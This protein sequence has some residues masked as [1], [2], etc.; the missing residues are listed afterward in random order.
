MYDIRYGQNFD[1]LQD[2]FDNQTVVTQDMV[3]NGFNI[4]DPQA[5]GLGENAVLLLPESGSMLFKYVLH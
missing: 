4:S 1:G 5:P 2:D 3:I